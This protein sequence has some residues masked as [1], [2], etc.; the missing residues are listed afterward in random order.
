MCYRYASELP[1]R[2]SCNHALP[3]ALV[4]VRCHVKKHFQLAFFSSSPKRPSMSPPIRHNAADSLCMY[5]QILC[6][7]A[8]R[9]MMLCWKNYLVWCPAAFPI[10]PSAVS[11][12]SCRGCCRQVCT[13][14]IHMYNVTWTF[15]FFFANW[16]SRS[17]QNL[18]HPMFD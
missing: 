16:P 15:H 1:S 10:L 3:K 12:L 2:K 9:A 7:P 11:R 18:M 5:S 17:T 6:R 14:V 8:N 13:R 4:T